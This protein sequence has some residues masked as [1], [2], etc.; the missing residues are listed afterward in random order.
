MSSDSPE[1]NSLVD[2]CL[3][4]LEVFLAEFEDWWVKSVV[5]ELVVKELVGI[6]FVFSPTGAFTWV[7]PDLRGKLG[8]ACSFDCRPKLVSLP[9]DELGGFPVRRV[10]GTGGFLV[11]GTGTS[12]S[13]R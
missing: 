3:L 8:T 4:L 6:V 9:D 7:S 5:K 10:V 2:F 11:P 13:G 1:P 12:S